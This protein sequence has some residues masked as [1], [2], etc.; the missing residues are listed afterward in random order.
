[1]TDVDDIRVREEGSKGSRG[2]R[3][4][5]VKGGGGQRK[6]GGGSKGEEVHTHHTHTHTHTHTHAHTLKTIQS[7]KQSN[8]LAVTFPWPTYTRRTSRIL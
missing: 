8:M 7:I 5:G 4:G 2:R 3:G 1:M 6:E